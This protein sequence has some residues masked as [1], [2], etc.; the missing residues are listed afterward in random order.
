MR[1][2]QICFSSY[3]LFN[4]LQYGLS[5]FPGLCGLVYLLVRS[6]YLHFWGKVVKA[7]SNLLI[8]W[9]N[10]MLTMIRLWTK[11]TNVHI[12][13]NPLVSHTPSKLPKEIPF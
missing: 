2:G 5:I 12:L 1:M 9:R 8:F 6:W 11:Y 7:T 13:S 10:K 3:L 4:F